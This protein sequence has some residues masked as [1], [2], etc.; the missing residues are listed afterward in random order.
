MLVFPTNTMPANSYS[1]N[2]TGPVLGGI[3]MP[4]TTYS[5]AGTQLNACAIG[6]LGGKAF[7]SD[8]TALVPGTAY[9]V[10]AGAGSDAVLGAMCARR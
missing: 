1:G 8:A 9:S 2:A 6:T 7:V 10:S 5:H 4:G 3:I